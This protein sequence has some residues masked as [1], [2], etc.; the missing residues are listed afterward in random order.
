MV[1]RVDATACA[2]ELNDGIASSSL[3]SWKMWR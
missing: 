1:Y 3:V 2:S